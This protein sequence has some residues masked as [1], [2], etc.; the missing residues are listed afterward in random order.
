MQYD[1][2]HINRALPIYETPFWRR[3]SLLSKCSRIRAIAP[4]LPMQQRGVGSAL[5]KSFRYRAYSVKASLAHRRTT[6][7][8]SGRQK[9]LYSERKSYVFNGYVRWL[10]SSIDEKIEKLIASIQFMCF[11]T[12]KR[13]FGHAFARRDVDDSTTARPA[14]RL[15]LPCR[16]RRP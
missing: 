16:R 2:T 9:T 5:A 7:F 10:K 6:R 14:S 8:C 1:T 15:F 13:P 11:G 4:Y 3:L 12:G